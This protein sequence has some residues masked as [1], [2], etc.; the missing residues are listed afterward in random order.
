LRQQ[1]VFGY[2]AVT[3]INKLKEKALMP[4]FFRAFVH[5]IQ[6]QHPGLKIF[7]DHVAFGFLGVFSV[8]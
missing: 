1:R 8:R 2:V 5:F 3:P 4:L 6:D 7:V